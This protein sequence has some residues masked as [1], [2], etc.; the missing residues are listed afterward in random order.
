[1]GLGFLVGGHGIVLRSGYDRRRRSTSRCSAMISLSDT[2]G[3]L[4]ST[5]NFLREDGGG[6]NPF[7]GRGDV[8]FLLL[9]GR[10]M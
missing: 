1:M 2:R 3:G 4:Q 6:P 9:H 5:Y 7:F 10:G 8:L